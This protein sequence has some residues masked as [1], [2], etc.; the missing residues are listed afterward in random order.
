MKNIKFNADYFRKL[1]EMV[2]APLAK[3][4]EAGYPVEGKK[5]NDKRR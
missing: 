4:F 2:E 3:R 1:R 5:E